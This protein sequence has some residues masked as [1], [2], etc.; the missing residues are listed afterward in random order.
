MRFPKVRWRSRNASSRLWQTTWKGR[1]A[2]AVV[3]SAAAGVPT[4][5]TPAAPAAAA[6]VAAIATRRLKWSRW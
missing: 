3:A 5:T 2:T 1:G 6:P 4:T